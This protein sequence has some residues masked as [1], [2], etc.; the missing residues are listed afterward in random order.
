[1]SCWKSTMSNVTTRAA[2]NESV[3]MTGTKARRP[4]AIAR[5]VVKRER[6]VRPVTTHAFRND[7]VQ[8]IPSPDEI[9]EHGVEAVVRTLESADVELRG[10]DDLRELLVERVRFA[11]ANEEG[12]GG[13]E[14]EGDEV[15]HPGQGLAEL[16]RFGRLVPHRVRMGVDERADRVD[17]AGRDRL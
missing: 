4:V 9:P 7:S 1:M 6:T 11:G 15:L 8:P 10:R 13:R 5:R 3:R 16:R 17:V 2:A 14:L 12:V